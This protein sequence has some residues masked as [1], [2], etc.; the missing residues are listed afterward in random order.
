M[1]GIAQMGRVVPTREKDGGFRGNLNA[2]QLAT[3]KHKRIEQFAN[4]VLNTPQDLHVWN[5]QVLSW[6]LSLDED[7]AGIW[8]AQLSQRY[9]ELGKTELAA[10]TMELLATRMSEHALSPAALTWLVQY[11]AS[12]EMGLIA[13]R[14]PGIQNL[15]ADS[16]NVEN[17]PDT[18]QSRPTEVDVNGVSKLVWVPV[19]QKA[20]LG[21]K[22][23]LDEIED[24]ALASHNSEAGAE[25]KTAVANEEQTK[26]FFQNRWQLASQFLS[27]LSQRDPDLV[28]GSQYRIIEAQIN[29][30]LN[31]PLQSESLLKLLVQLGDFTQT[32]ISTGAQRE[33][34]IGGIL[35]ETEN[36]LHAMTCQ[37]ASVRP[38]LD[39]K[40]DDDVWNDA[41]ERGSEQKFERTPSESNIDDQPD[42]AMFAFDDQFLYAAFRC[43]KLKGQYYQTTPQPRPRD[44]DLTRR[45]RVEFSIDVDRDYRSANQFVVDYRGWAAEGCAGSKGWDPTWFVS[46]TDDADTWTIELAI[47][48]EQ[49]VPGKIKPDSVWAVR[50]AR[51]AF[52]S[53]NLWDANPQKSDEVVEGLHIGFLSQPAHFELMRVK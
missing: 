37:R 19:K 36:P 20:V 40:L 50:F 43:R 18:F 14:S 51:R 31:G 48:L 46:R 3:S 24:I 30:K 8:L 17:S 38:R 6:I 45:D 21:Q 4:F 7:V 44:P 32:G 27:R 52:D 23:E 53:T 35:L 13:F 10:Y 29:R 9:L 49:I 41:L 22:S 15:L 39:G 34:V 16:S 26:A 12:D 11:Y 5:Q 47:P 42:L 1:A 25:S 28:V 33:L 2:I